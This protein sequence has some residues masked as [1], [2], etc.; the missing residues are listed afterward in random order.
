MNRYIIKNIKSY[1]RQA[2]AEFSEYTGELLAHERVRLLDKYSQHYTYT[3]LK[4]SLSVAYRSFYIAKILKLD[5]RSVARGGLL[6]DLSFHES[7]NLREN[8]K[9]LRQHPKDALINALAICELNKIEQDII[10]KHMWMITLAPPKYKEGYIV[11][12]VDKYCA[13][14]EFF[15]SVFTK[16]KTRAVYSE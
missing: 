10:L 2:R 1:N 12:F 7:G 8:M 13:A 4:H 14:K 15:I 5:C 9:M 6:H 3:R 16:K 11:T